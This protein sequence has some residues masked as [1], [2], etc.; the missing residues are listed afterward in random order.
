MRACLACLSAVGLLLIAAAFAPDGMCRVTLTLTDADT[1]RPLAGVVRIT[2]KD[3]DQRVV[4][5]PDGLDSRGWGLLAKQPDIADWFVVPQAATIELPRRSVTLEAFSGLETETA[6]VELDLSNGQPRDVSISLKRFRKSHERGWRSANTHLHLMK[7]TRVESDR[8]L[9]DFPA[10]DGLDV[11]FVSHLKRAGADQDY[12]TNQYPTGR[13]KFLETRGVLVSN[14]EEHRHNFGAGG[15]GYGHVMLLGLKEL[16]QPVSIGEGIAK[17]PPDFPPLA[18]GLENAH[19]QDGTAIWC[20]NN[21]W[22]EDIPNWLAGRLDAQNIFD[23]GSHGSFADSFYHYLNAGLKVPF[24]T[25]TD[26]FMDDFARVYAELEGELSPETW[27][28][29]LR[30]GCTVITNGPLLEFRVNNARIGDTL[31][32][33][34]PGEVTVTASAIGRGNFELLEIVYNGQVIASESSAATSGHFTATIR[35]PIKVSEPGWLAAR[36]NTANKNEYGRTLFGHTSAVY[37][38]IAGR[39]IRR[40]ADV[41]WLRHE[42]EDARAAITEKAQFDTAEQRAKVLGLYDQALQKLSK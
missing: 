10:A 32:L 41:A 21:W 12:I 25:G 1:G 18:M 14:G 8:Y 27:L 7:L 3:G 5:K 38:T 35:R 24:S 30:A 34:Q 42:V 20:H 2:H 22:F 37:V 40:A 29:A 15:E 9:R 17:T 4:L 23:G 36:I 31:D 6:K 33:A 13:L 11:L 39:T 19:Q 16:V 28:A 26:W